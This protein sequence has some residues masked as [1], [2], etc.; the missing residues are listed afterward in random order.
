[1]VSSDLLVIS[2]IKKVSKS[3]ITR[4]P[5][6][7]PLPLLEILSLI[8]YTLC[9]REVPVFGFLTSSDSSLSKSL[10]KEGYFLISGLAAIIKLW[11]IRTEL[12][13]KELF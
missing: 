13:L 7:L 11:V 12:S 8:L 9:P 2:P 5:P 3:E 1:M 10:D 6:L 4:A